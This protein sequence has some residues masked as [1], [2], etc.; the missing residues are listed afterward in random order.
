MS[1]R[2]HAAISDHES[3]NEALARLVD[4]AQP[5]LES[6]DVAFLFFTS[7]HAEQAEEL[8]E[9]LMLEFEPQA[10]V[11]CSCDG[12][13]GGDREIERSPGMALMLGNLPGVQVHSFQVGT[14]DWREM[15][16]DRAALSEKLGIGEE[17]RAV[18]G[19]G[20]PWTTPLSQFLGAMDAAAPHAPL[21]GGMASGARQGGGNRL[22]R[23]DSV[24][25]QGFVGVSLSGA[26][27]VQTVVSQGCKPIGQPMVVTRAKD[28][29][30]EQL[31]GKPA[32]LALREVINDLSAEDQKLLQHGLLIGRAIS[33]YRETFRRGDFLV[34]NIIG[35]DQDTGSLSMGDF[36][37]VGQTIQFQVRDAATADEDL[38]AMLDGIAPPAGALLFSCN[39]R[40]TNLFE[41]PNHD[42]RVTRGKLENPPVV[43][44]FA[45]GE[46]GPVGGKNFIHGHTASLALFRKAQP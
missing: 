46:I 11:G 23:N 34:R 12:V 4:D 45:A 24:T 20:D 15:I 44:F 39:G 14:D 40:G 31:G 29:I 43:G 21:I 36:V 41:V 1:I 30:I 22:I 8:A 26:I 25:S 10:L 7:H 27:E 3:S 35:A 2:F 37:R 6:A 9:K 19:L 17:T 18:I 5:H 32:L 33:E 13:I 16:Q 28:N 38:L 42:V